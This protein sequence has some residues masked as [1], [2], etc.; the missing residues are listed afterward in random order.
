[1][2]KEKTQG[3][4]RRETFYEKEDKKKKN[5]RRERDLKDRERQRFYF[6]V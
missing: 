5:T 3:R 1:L 6:N 4:E 2:G